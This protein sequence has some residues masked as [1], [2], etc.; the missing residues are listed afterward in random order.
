MDTY[1]LAL[2]QISEVFEMERAVNTAKLP[3]VWQIGPSWEIRYPYGDAWC[4]TA[5]SPSLSPPTQSKLSDNESAFSQQSAI[6]GDIKGNS[7]TSSDSIFSI[8]KTHSWPKQNRLARPVF[9]KHLQFKSLSNSFTQR[10]EA[11]ICWSNLSLWTVER[12]AEPA[13]SGFLYYILCLIV[14]LGLWTAGLAIT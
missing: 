4:Y 7:E 10:N 1:A 14:Q 8:C 9:E 2:W 11:H 12:A 5:L 6:R 3:Q 13:E